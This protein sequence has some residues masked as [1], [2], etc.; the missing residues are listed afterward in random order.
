MSQ[1]GRKAAIA[2]PPLSIKNGYLKWLP[3]YTT[4]WGVHN[5]LSLCTEHLE[6]TRAWPTLLTVATAKV[7]MGGKGTLILEI[8]KGPRGGASSRQKCMEYLVAIP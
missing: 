5:L 8:G 1:Q 2:M 4:F 3:G 6:L 7:R